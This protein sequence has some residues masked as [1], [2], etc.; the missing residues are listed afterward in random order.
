MS[1]P[2]SKRLLLG[3]TFLIATPTL[4]N[5]AVDQIVVT[6]S[7]RAKPSSELAAPITVLSREQLV[8]QGGA[9]LGELLSQ[10]PGVTDSSFARGASRPIIR[11]LDNFRVRLQEN[12]IGSHDV[13]DL[14]EDH[15][16]PIDPL[17]AQ[18]IEIIRG[19]ATLR[20]GSQ[21]I[22][23][24]VSVLNNRIP[25]VSPDNGVAG[26]VYGAYSS[27]DEGLE[28]SALIDFGEG[29]FAGHLDAFYRDADDY[30]TPNGTKPIPAM[31]QQVSPQVARTI[32]KA[33][34]WVVRFLILKANMVFRAVKLRRET[35]S[36]TLN[37]PN[38]RSRARNQ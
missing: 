7:P 5:A 4:G 37:K 23:G 13:S 8:R 20:Y 27:V 24:V 35:F 16:A 17:A 11:G 9:T 28:T 18:R 31:N 32:L 14:S 34:I 2:I 38:M 3:A 29:Q 12:G 1:Y 21:A 22:G 6:A 36:L 25:T 19:P 30:E 10:V 15:G 33:G 26:E